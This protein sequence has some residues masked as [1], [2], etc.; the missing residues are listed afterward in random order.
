MI[1]SV[2]QGAINFI[3]CTNCVISVYK[4]KQAVKF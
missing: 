1:E 2:S 4:T 3:P